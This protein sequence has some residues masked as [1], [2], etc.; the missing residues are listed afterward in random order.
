MMIMELLWNPN[1][2]EA[3]LSAPIIIATLLQCPET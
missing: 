1:P 2:L 3:L